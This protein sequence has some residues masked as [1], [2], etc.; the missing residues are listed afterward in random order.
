MFYING[1]VRERRNSIANAME[2]RLTCTNPWIL[3]RQVGHWRWQGNDVIFEVV[4]ANAAW[5][6]SNGKGSHDLTKL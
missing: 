6:I 2:L 5:D 1:L 4:I 3:S